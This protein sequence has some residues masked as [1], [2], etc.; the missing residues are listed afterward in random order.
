MELTVE[1]RQ[2]V[3]NGDVVKYVIPGSHV[4]CVVVREDML[5]PLRPIGLF[6]LRHGRPCRDDGGGLAGRRMD[7]AGRTADATAVV[8]KRRLCK[9]IA[10]T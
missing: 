1:E 9:S 7:H 10:V 4:G 2:A 3:E 5:D 6:G 8:S